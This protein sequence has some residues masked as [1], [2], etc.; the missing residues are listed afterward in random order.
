MVTRRGGCSEFVVED[1][2]DGEDSVPEGE[3]NCRRGCCDGRSRALLPSI[4]KHTTERSERFVI[5][6]DLCDGSKKN[7]L[8][9]GSYGMKPKQLKLAKAQCEGSGLLRLS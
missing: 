4:N 7:I 1:S 5:S 2:L 3:P 6:D 8:A 9:Q